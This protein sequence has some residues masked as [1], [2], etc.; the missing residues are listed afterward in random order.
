MGSGES[1]SATP[2]GSRPSAERASTAAGDAAD[3]SGTTPVPVAEA[4]TGTGSR[5]L[6]GPAVATVATD[7][8]PAP[9]GAARAARPASTCSAAIGSSPPPAA[10]ERSGAPE[11]P[12]L[13]G[14]R[15]Q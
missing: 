6:G 11:G 8:G 14:A 15:R 9:A 4:E 13:E 2:A 12:G 10:P 1:S 7:A 5:P 3:A